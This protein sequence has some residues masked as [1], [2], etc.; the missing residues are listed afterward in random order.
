MLTLSLL[1]LCEF[2]DIIIEITFTGGEMMEFILAL[3]VIIVVLKIMGVSNFMLVAGGMAIVELAI[4]SMVIFFIFSMIL[5][6]LSKSRKA[7]FSKIDKAPKDGKFKVAY[8]I[9]EGEELPCIFPSE[10]I[11]NDQMYKKGR[12]YHVLYNKRMKKVFDIWTILTIVL[13]FFCSGAAL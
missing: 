7:E 4:L 8:Y 2:C 1:T 10:M 13:G 11:L 3:I 6:A 9:V 5:L 12:I